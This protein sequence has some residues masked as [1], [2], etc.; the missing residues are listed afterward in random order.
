LD[1]HFTSGGDFPE[2]L[3]EYS[4]IVHC[5]G[6]MLTDRILKN[7]LNC[8]KDAGAKITNYGVLIAYMQGIL[9][10]CVKVFGL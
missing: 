8:V 10:R 9:E 2:N 4:L 6:C 7:R 1:F 3:S 5:G